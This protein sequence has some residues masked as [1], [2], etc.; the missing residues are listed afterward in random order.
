MTQHPHKPTEKPIKSFK[1]MVDGKPYETETQLV[2]GAYLKAT[3][4]IEPA[5]GLFL[6]S[7]G[8]APDVQVGDQ[9]TIDL[10]EPGREQFYTVPPATF[11]LR[12]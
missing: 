7:H 8:Q 9:D 10:S 5:F 4:A 6:E 12:Q 11:G 1:F 3:A 2:T